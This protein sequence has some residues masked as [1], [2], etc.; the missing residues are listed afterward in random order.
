METIQIVLD[1]R[2][3]LSGTNT[4][5]FYKLQKNYFKTD[6]LYKLSIKCHTLYANLQNAEN[7]LCF[8]Y[9][10]NLTNKTSS[11]LNLLGVLRAPYALITGTHERVS[12]EFENEIYSYGLLNELIN[13]K[14]VNS[15]NTVP[16]LTTDPNYVLLLQFTPIE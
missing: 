11:G 14:I 16:Y 15:A 1:S 9:I 10:D 12:Y 4:N 7:Q 2:S 5:A 3:K 6:Q 8:V 13:V